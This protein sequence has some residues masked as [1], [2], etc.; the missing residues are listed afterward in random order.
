MI[1]TSSPGATGPF[2][3]L[4]PL[5]GVFAL[6][7]ALFVVRRVEADEYMLPLLSLITLVGGVFHL[8]LDGPGG[9]AIR[10][11]RSDVLIGVG[12]L[13]ETHAATRSTGASKRQ[14]PVWRAITAVRRCTS[15]SRDVSGGASGPRGSREPRSG[16]VGR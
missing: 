16:P 8:G 10:T 3:K 6:L 4:A 9:D 1:A 7:H 15:R 5:W 13:G 14:A 2:A 11:Y 12:V